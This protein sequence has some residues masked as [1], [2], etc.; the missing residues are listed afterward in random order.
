MA[1]HPNTPFRMVPAPDYLVKGYSSN[2][3]IVYGTGAIV[4]SA[5]VPAQTAQVFEN[6]KVIYA[7]VRS[8]SNNCY[9]ARIDRDYGAASRACPYLAH[10]A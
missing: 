2:D 5:E 4:P 3:R 9:L 10:W 8:A 6:P 1:K 7:H